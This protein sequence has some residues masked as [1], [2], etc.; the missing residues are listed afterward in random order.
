MTAKHPCER[1]YMVHSTG[2]FEPSEALR[3]F[4]WFCGNI[5]IMYRLEIATLDTAYR[6]P[7]FLKIPSGGD[8]YQVHACN[9]RADQQGAQPARPRP[10]D[11]SRVFFV[12]AHWRHSCK[13]RGSKQCRHLSRNIDCICT[14]HVHRYVTRQV[15]FAMHGRSSVGEMTS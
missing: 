8:A 7:S 13:G 3:I 6:P 10:A 9:V 5:L 1:R 15:S 2:Q 11:M 12:G 4:P 14:N